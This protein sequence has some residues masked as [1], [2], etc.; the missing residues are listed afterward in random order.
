[1]LK[2]IKIVSLN[3]EHLDAAVHLR[4]N[5]VEATITIGID[6]VS[7]GEKKP[8]AN[9][10]EPRDSM[11]RVTIKYRH[12]LSARTSEDAPFYEASVITQ[13][14]ADVDRAVYP[15]VS[16]S[17]VEVF[18]FLDEVLSYGLPAS[19]EKIKSLCAAI[20]ISPLPAIPL[21]PEREDENDDVEIGN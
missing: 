19:A 10:A 2:S 1:M 5:K 8:K 20:G 17:S 16:N 6:D 11:E 18:T 13:L 15:G 3:F 4:K 9:D 7:I 21:T 14:V 12:Y